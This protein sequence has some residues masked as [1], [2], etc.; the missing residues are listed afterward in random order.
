[1]VR[2]R[3]CRQPRIEGRSEFH[4]T[5]LLNLPTVSRQGTL[6]VAQEILQHKLFAVL[7]G[8]LATKSS[9]KRTTTF[10]PRADPADATLGPVM[11]N[12]VPADFDHRHVIPFRATWK[13]SL[14]CW[15]RPP[16]IRD[17]GYGRGLSPRIHWR[18]SPCLACI[19]TCVTWVEHAFCMA[20]RRILTT[21]AVTEV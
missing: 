19:P 7:L 6:N 17:P 15:H 13:T 9:T 18:F 14:W 10:V 3:S 8:V 5:Y 21:E 20:L 11:T 4:R 16:R 12:P 1:M 2:R